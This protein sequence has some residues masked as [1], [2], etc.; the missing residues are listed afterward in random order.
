MQMTSASEL[1]ALESRLRDR[2][3][4]PLP[5]AG[6][7]LRFAPRPHLEG[8]RPDDSPTHARRAAA[9]IL[10]YPTEDGIALPLTIRHSALPH[11]AGQV[12]LPGGRIDLDESAEHAALR[13]TEEEIG[14]SRDRVRVL[15]PLS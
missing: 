6:A 13:E 5:G 15:G 4:H 3:R 10:L 9:L 7:H 12:S 8:W 1:A 14:V 2:L 11:H